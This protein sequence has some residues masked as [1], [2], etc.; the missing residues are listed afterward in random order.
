[1]ENPIK[2]YP[3]HILRLLEPEGF[4]NRFH[5]HIKQEKSYQEAYFR[6]EEEHLYYFGK[7][8]YADYESFRKIK[9]NYLKRNGKKSQ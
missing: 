9:Y 8:K 7:T 4:I 1:M 6:C 2:V 5:E 3:L